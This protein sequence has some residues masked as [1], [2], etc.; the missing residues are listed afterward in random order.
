[1][2][3]SGTILTSNTSDTTERENIYIYIIFFCTYMLEIQIYLFIKQ[4]PQN[5]LCI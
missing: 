3:D 1:M 5:E 4:E 2:E